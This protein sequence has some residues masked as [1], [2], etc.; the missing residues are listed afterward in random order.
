MGQIPVFRAAAVKTDL[1]PNGGR[2][3]AGKA[4]TVAG[5]VLTQKRRQR[6]YRVDRHI[7]IP[8][9]LAAGINLGTGVIRAHQVIPSAQS[10][11][12]VLGGHGVF[13]LHQADAGEF[14]RKAVAAI[15]IRVSL[16][17]EDTG[18]SVVPV[19]QANGQ[20]PRP[21][22]G[23][24][25]TI[26]I[27]LVVQQIADPVV[28]QQNVVARQV[29]AAFAQVAIQAAY[30]A[31]GI[32]GG[33]VA[34]FNGQIVH[35]N[36]RRIVLVVALIVNLTNH[37]AGDSLSDD[38]RM[39]Q[40]DIGER[41]AG[42]QADHT[43]QAA[44]N[45]VGAAVAAR[46]NLNGAALGTNAHLVDGH[47][48]SRVLHQAD[49]AAQ[50]SAI[51]HPDSGAWFPA[52]GHIR[53]GKMVGRV[54]EVLP[55]VGFCIAEETKQTAYV[56]LCVCAFP[57]DQ[58]HLSFQADALD[59]YG[60]TLGNALVAHQAAYGGVIRLGDGAR[61]LQ[62]PD[63]HNGIA[64]RRVDFQGTRSDF[65]YGIQVNMAEESSRVLTAAVLHCHVEGGCRPD[66]AAC[67]LH[68]LG[69]ADSYLHCRGVAREAAGHN[70]RPNGQILIGAVDKL[71]FVLELG[72]KPDHA[73]EASR[74][75]A[76]QGVRAP[77]DAGIFQ[78]N[79][80]EDNG[81]VSGGAE[82]ADEHTRR[83][84]IG[85]FL[86]IPQVAVLSQDLACLAGA[87]TFVKVGNSGVSGENQVGEGGIFGIAQRQ[88]QAGAADRP[89]VLLRLILVALLVQGNDRPI[90]VGFCSVHSLNMQL[91]GMVE[92]RAEADAHIAAAD[93]PEAVAVSP[94]VAVRREL[95]GKQQGSQ[96]AEIPGHIF[97]QIA[98]GRGLR[99]QADPAKAGVV[100]LIASDSG[101]AEAVGLELVHR[102]GAAVGNGGKQPQPLR[103]LHRSGGILARQKNL[104]VGIQ[105][106]PG[107]NI[108]NLVILIR[109]FQGNA[110]SQH[111]A[112]QHPS[113]IGIV[114]ELAAV[115]FG[116][117][118]GQAGADSSP[119]HY[120]AAVLIIL[121]IAAVAG[122]VEG[123]AH[124]SHI[125][126]HRRQIGILALGLRRVRN[127]N[128]NAVQNGV[129]AKGIAHYAAKEGRADF[130]VGH[131]G[132]AQ[133]NTS[134]VF[135]G[136]VANHAAH[137]V[138]D[139]AAKL[140]GCAARNGE[141]VTCAV[142]LAAE[143]DDLAAGLA[144]VRM[145]QAVPV[146]IGGNILFQL[147]MG[148]LQVQPH[149][150]RFHDA[151]V[152]AFPFAG[153]RRIGIAYMS[154]VHVHIV[155]GVLVRIHE[156]FP[157]FLLNVCQHLGV[158][159]HR[160][161]LGGAVPE[162]L[163]QGL[164]L[165]EL[166]DDIRIRPGSAA[167]LQSGGVQVHIQ[168]VLGAANG[169]IFQ[170]V[171]IT[172]VILIEAVPAVG[173]AANQLAFQLSTVVPTLLIV[174]PAVYVACGGVGQLLPQCAGF[175]LRLGKV[176]DAAGGG[177][178]IVKGLQEQS[179]AENAAGSAIHRGVVP[180][181]AAVQAHSLEGQPDF[182][183]GS[184]AHLADQTAGGIFVGFQIVV[185]GGGF[186]AAHVQGAVA[187]QAVN[188]QGTHRVGIA[189]L[190]ADS[191][192]RQ[193]HILD[194]Q[195]HP[196]IDGTAGEGPA[197]QGS[198]AGGTASH[199]AGQ[200][201][202]VYVQLLVFIRGRAAV[203]NARVHLIMLAVG[204][205]QRLVGCARLETVHGIIIEGDGRVLDGGI[206]DKRGGIEGIA[207][208]VDLP[209][210]HKA[211]LGGK[212]PPQVLFAIM[213][214]IPKHQL[215]RVVHSA[216]IG[217][218]D[219]GAGFGVI[220]QLVPVGIQIIVVPGL[221]V[222][223]G[224]PQLR[225]IGI[226][227]V[228]VDEGM[229]RKGNGHN[230]VVVAGLV[231]AHN[232]VKILGAA[233]IHGSAL[234][235]VS[236]LSD[237]QVQGGVAVLFA[238]GH[239]QTAGGVLLGFA[240]ED[241]AADKV[242]ARS[243]R[244]L[245]HPP[246]AGA[247]ID[248][249]AEPGV[250]SRVQSAVFHGNPGD[251]CP[252]IQPLIAQQTTAGDVSVGRNGQSIHRQAV[253]GQL[254]GAVVSQRRSQ[255][256]HYGIVFRLSFLN[257]TGNPAVFHE[258]CGVLSFVISGI[259]TAKRTVGLCG[260][261]NGACPFAICEGG[262]RGRG[263]NAG[264]PAIPNTIG[265]IGFRI[266]QRFRISGDL[267]QRGRARC[268]SAQWADI[269][270][271]TCM[272]SDFAVHRDIGG[273][274]IRGFC[275]ESLAVVII[276]AGVDRDIRQG[277]GVTV[278]VQRDA[279]RCRIAHV[280]LEAGNADVLQII[281]IRGQ[282]DG[283][284]GIQVGISV[285]KFQGVG[286]IQLIAQSQ[287]RKFGGTAHRVG[288]LSA[289]GGCHGHRPFG[290]VI[291][292]NAGQL[293]GANHLTPAADVV[294]SVLL[295]VPDLVGVYQGVVPV[296][297]H[298]A[299]F[300]AGAGLSNGNL[301]AQVHYALL[302]IAHQAA[303]GTVS[304][305]AGGRHTR[306]PQHMAAAIQL[307]DEAAYMVRRVVICGTGG[308]GL[309]NFNI[310]AVIA[311]H[312][313]DDAAVAVAAVSG[314]GNFPGIHSQRLRRQGICLVSAHQAAQAIALGGG[315]GDGLLP[316]QVE[317]LCGVS[318]I[319]IAVQTAYV[320]VA[321]GQVHV[322]AG[323]AVAV[324]VVAGFRV[325][326]AADQAACRGAAGNFR[327]SHLRHT[328]VQNQV[329]RNA[330]QAARV[331]SGLNGT[332]NRD[333]G[334]SGQAGKPGTVL[335]F[336][337]Q[338]ARIA[339]AQIRLDG[340]LI[341]FGQGKDRAVTH[342][343][344]QTAGA[345]AGRY[346]GDIQSQIA[347]HLHL[348]FFPHLAYQTA[349]AAAGRYLGD[350][351]SQAARHRR[352]GVFPHLAYQ[353]AAAAT[354]IDFTGAAQAAGNR[355]GGILAHFAHQTAARAGGGLYLGDIQS[356]VARHRHLGVFPHLAYQ[357]A[358]GAAS[359][360]YAGAGQA[361]GNCQGS[362]LAHFAHQAAARAGGGGGGVL[363]RIPRFF[364][365]DLL[366]VL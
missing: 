271:R 268:L 87:A 94:H 219:D 24:T 49:Q 287:L 80:I 286:F 261:H 59:G 315:D 208:Q 336:A 201:Q 283:L 178:H 217:A 64:F 68:I 119:E 237:F 282:L 56:G 218:V 153:F 319:H 246:I 127:G 280:P 255:A 320:S 145:T 44:G 176:I 343:A 189:R 150:R 142:N 149:N 81:V 348:G 207:T 161:L 146:V 262:V 329:F 147:I 314:E 334:G 33:N 347:R 304:G 265:I 69:I 72:R 100:L 156:G 182:L 233:D 167:D 132:A 50:L 1:L 275:K 124:K 210:N 311:M 116:L 292:Q 200:F 234:G 214:G 128:R 71:G 202:S 297:Q 5:D 82:A 264:N 197:A 323:V 307:A 155:P 120:A 136:D 366:V 205:P 190:F 108:G 97:A 250:G 148:V 151:L 342:F 179:P 11:S 175:L 129:A 221:S 47:L 358:A 133:G 184:A 285:R 254:M 55:L 310:D 45:A 118:A 105:V 102:R 325:G 165:A 25:P 256:A 243:R 312:A 86:L 126:A 192:S 180:S 270:G 113:H 174:V 332:A 322:Y 13:P 295:G 308:R 99:R 193:I 27:F 227:F 123:A 183:A 40:A 73:N 293:V 26:V 330:D 220:A 6:A 130:A 141:G 166:G 302:H 143:G 203:E 278:A 242:N 115:F 240:G 191:D 138:L 249:A 344:H 305:K 231:A 274:E 238:L 101:A 251:G 66:I 169:Q 276:A 139:Q 173:T 15:R 363:D 204:L 10:R 279:H 7:G 89:F 244:A 187:A 160:P 39:I 111:I 324:I 339:A 222:D 241:I 157:R 272:G 112:V 299:V 267:F 4:G 288:A 318:H 235:L 36:L 206:V 23:H 266:Y 195:I 96:L 152:L 211:L 224:S 228:S 349:A 230:A 158:Q 58:L 199:C 52:D 290:G 63:G 361:A 289:V 232:F 350:I 38:C 109:I 328:A 327:G 2:S 341:G 22:A 90:A 67:Q 313:A 236:V 215:T 17:A 257:F 91:A 335:H 144:G 331:L 62:I 239:N 46:E 309:L 351:Q 194:C 338:T 85:P 353:T 75:G 346:L 29:G 159:I 168:L 298:P 177:L 172:C 77:V 79:P 43:Q 212:I 333:L 60:L 98:L 162:H 117:P 258:N 364:L 185:A 326:I 31:L 247:G 252:G 296:A 103:V 355:Q 269:Q 226:A 345:A 196:V 357:T 229:A 316:L 216:Q 209:G 198:R 104:Q 356:Q 291:S 95:D 88:E 186:H 84:H 70:Q 301:L 74:G 303:A 30:A 3:A 21:F 34:V 263:E 321:V 154:A 140:A 121:I 134:G 41:Y 245:L 122:S 65:A 14:Q 131:L 294:G 360:D 135:D 32:A 164:Q 125:A 359:I 340:E 352:L 12:K 37:S 171:D 106:S 277:D 225:L 93:S 114:V 300:A 284:G 28:L 48:S 35:L 19:Y 110:V 281:H 83:R 188:Q 213:V 181:G 259:K 16:S 365:R 137:A 248:Q 337:H 273:G 76:A 78:R 61:Y 8:V 163:I 54:R 317:I 92:R 42:I 53:N 18:F 306:Q 223:P 253:D 354:G 20:R 260:F 9:V 51:Y 362:I 170:L 57:A 107:G